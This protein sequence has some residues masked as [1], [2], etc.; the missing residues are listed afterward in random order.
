MAEQDFK[1]RKGLVVSEDATIGGTLTVDS[2]LAVSGDLNVTGTITGDGSGLSGVTSYV[3]SDFDSDL[4]TKTT[5]DLDEGTNLYYTTARA[6]SDAKNAISVSGDLAYNAGTGV[7]SFTETPYTSFDS[8]FD[9]KSTSDLSEGSNLY[10]TT[11]RADSDFD[12][13]LATKD[14]GDV[15]EGSNLYYTTARVD[16]DIDVAFAAKST[17]DVSEGNNLY[18][19]TARA[20]SD[21]DARLSG[22]TGVSVSSGEVSI[23][24]PVGTTDNVT[25]GDITADTVK[26]LNYLEFDGTAPSYNEGRLWYDSA[27]GALA[28]YGDEADITLQI[29]QEFFFRVYNNTGSTI[30]NGTPVYVTG[31]INGDVT[32]AP[33]DASDADKYQARGI[34]THDIEDASHGYITRA[35]IVNGIDTSALTAGQMLFVSDTNPGTLTNTSPSYPNFPTC[36]GACLVSDSNEGKILVDIQQH[37]VE[38]FRT[39]GDAFVGAD[40]TVGGDFTV[41]G[42]SSTI[43]VANLSVDDQFIYLQGGNDIGDNTTFIGTGLS[44]MLVVG[45]FEGTA[46]TNFYIRI[47]SVGDQDTFE[48][49]KDNFSTTEATGVLI[50]AGQDITLGDGYK[51]NFAAQT[52]HTLNDTWTWVS[53]PSNLDFGVTSHYATGGTYAHA[54]MFRDAADNRFKFFTGYE[55]EVETSVDTSDASYTDA[56]IQFGTGYGNLVGN[57]T[58]ALTGNASTATTLASSRNFS[59]TG[60]ITASAV[61]FNG[62][63]NVALNASIDA[64]SVTNTMLAGSIANSKLSNSSVTI[65]TTGIS[66]GSSST[67]LAGLTSVSSTAFTGNLTGN[68]TGNVTG[69]SGSTTGNAA[70]A[71]RLQTARTIGGVSFNGT[72]NINLPGVN[73]AGNQ[74]TSGNAA[75]ATTATNINALANNST[76]ESTYIA[77]LDGATGT[78][79]IET[80]TGLRYNPSTNTITASTFVGN[81][82]GNVTGNVTGSSGSTT[83]NA[84]TATRLQTARTIAGVSFNGTANISLSTSN[85]TEGSRLYYTTAR[86][87][88]DFG[89]QTTSDLTEGTNLYYTTARARSAVSVTDAGGDG[90]LSYNSGTGVLS[91]VGPSVADTRTKLSASGDLSYNS[92]TG[93]FSFNETYSTAA[94]LLTALKTVDGP[95]SGL[96][97]DLLDGR[98]GSYYRIDVFNSSGTLL[99]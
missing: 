64:G 71:T 47:D 19:T 57:V 90:S 51:V 77:F 31:E 69:S 70:T 24:Q 18:Y 34:A 16:S 89:D 10:Y 55:P 67:S 81:L 54:G 72:A 87:E 44:D 78:Q 4:A 13:R 61:S 23:G 95:G 84:A 80:D 85:I 36:I 32:V 50:T 68:V 59:I 11:A 28:F 92:S 96:N 25:F 20:D 98:S 83:G 30:T 49:S 99:N 48:W 43:S 2:D 5:S 26:S 14:T 56:N 97:A 46:T 52:G 53:N 21:F 93:V 91:Y 9:G 15:T 86:F 45:Y 6:D 8:D 40:L 88:N 63:G 29:G 39:E 33:A 65:G 79:R 17:T 41:L 74:S 58:G 22:G 82:T 94:E 37:S 27:Q 75:T 35:G 42:A 62:S 12:A 38:S 73:T 3:S 7:I 76:N 66:L 1:V 60:D